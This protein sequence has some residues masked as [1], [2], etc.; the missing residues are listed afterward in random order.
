MMRANDE[1]FETQ[2]KNYN[3]FRSGFAPA[4]YLKAMQVEEN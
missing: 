2:Q 4:A 1:L 3:K